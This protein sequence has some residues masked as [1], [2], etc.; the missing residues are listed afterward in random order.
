[1]AKS[2]PE[3]TAKT[4]SLEELR[5]L[6]DR[7]LTPAQIER[8]EEVARHTAIISAGVKPPASG[9]F[10]GTKKASTR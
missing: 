10:G 4:P 2:S 9:T 1:M 8:R 6:R 5:A 3:P 7:A